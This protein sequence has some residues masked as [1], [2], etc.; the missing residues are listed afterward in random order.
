MAPG[1]NPRGCFIGGDAV[2]ALEAERDE[3]TERVPLTTAE[4]MSLGIQIK[5][6]EKPKAE[7]RKQATQAKPGEQV[8]SQV[9]VT[10]RQP[11]SQGRT[12]DLVGKALGIGARTFER[13][14]SVY[15][16]AKEEPEKHG[17]L[18]E[19]MNERGVNPAYLELKRRREAERPTAQ[20]AQQP[21]REER[22]EPV[23]VVRP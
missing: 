1:G 13:G 5:A 8:G 7:A 15:E 14:S 19:V 4:L 23:K 6:L 2:K 18:I 16:A 22:I 21:Q 11:T 20:P 10:G 17:D 12:S 3:N 9:S